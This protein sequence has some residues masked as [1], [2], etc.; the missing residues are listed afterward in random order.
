MLTIHVEKM[1]DLTVVECAG[2]I[3]PSHHACQL[4]DAVMAQAAS[5]LIVLD[6]SEV[7]AI[8][9]A[10]LGMLALLDHWARERHIGFK[11]FHPSPAILQGLV[12]NRTILDFEIAGFHEMMRLVIQSGQHHSLAA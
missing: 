2:T 8:S 11:L 10:G 1:Y 9:G 4:R 5:H 3:L 6:L 12:R 7:E